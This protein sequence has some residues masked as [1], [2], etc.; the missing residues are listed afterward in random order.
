MVEVTSKVDIGYQ[1]ELWIGRGETPTWTQVL[2][3]ETLAMPEKVPEDVDV[4]HMQSP[5]RSRE[6]IPGLLAVGDWSQEIQYWPGEDH[7]V[8]LEELYAKNEEGDRE[9]ILIEFAY[10]GG[11]R[12]TYQGYVNSYIPTS[13]VGDKRMVNL[14]MKLF[15]RVDNTR[16]ID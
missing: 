14:S 11:T 16:T 1:D 15:G 2:G 6:T 8:I 5:G 10:D 9:V 4:T 3:I 12:R 7:D 13:S